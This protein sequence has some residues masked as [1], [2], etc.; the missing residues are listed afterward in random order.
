MYIHY[1]FYVCRSPSC[2]LCLSLWYSRLNNAQSSVDPRFTGSQGTYKIGNILHSRHREIDRQF[3]RILL[4][5]EPDLHC[6]CDILIFTVNII[7]SRGLFS[8][9]HDKTQHRLPL[10]LDVKKFTIQCHRQLI[11][12]YS[13]NKIQTN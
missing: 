1:W 5:N 13:T 3:L 12:N 4:T 7:C 2:P 10:Q 8:I 6:F 11:V 9:K